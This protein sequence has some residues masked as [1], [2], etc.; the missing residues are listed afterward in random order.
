MIDFTNSKINFDKYLAS[1]SKNMQHDRKWLMKLSMFFL[2][3]SSIVNSLIPDEFNEFIN[4]AMK[5]REETYIK[6]QSIN[7]K[8]KLEFAQLFKNAGVTSSN[9]GES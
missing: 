4:E 9:L 5:N 6:K 3:S 7:M 8:V 1:I 2:H